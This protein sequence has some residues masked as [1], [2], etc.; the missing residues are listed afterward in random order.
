MPTNGGARLSD[1][2]AQRLF[3][4]APAGSWHEDF[5]ER[6]RLERERGDDAASRGALAGY[7]VARLVERSLDGVE[8][9]EER[10]AYAWQLDS[11]RR[12]VAELDKRRPET[13]HLEGIVESIRSSQGASSKGVRLALNAFAYF[14]ENEGRLAEA[15]DMLGLAARTHRAAMPAGEF[16]AVALFA[17]RLNRLQARF[18]AATA[19]YAAAEEGALVAL[20]ANSR[21]ISWLGRAHVARAQGNLPVART[22][23]EG[24]IAEARAQGLTD[25]LSRAYADLGHVLAAMGD[26]L[27][28]LKATYEAFRLTHDPITRMRNL[29]DLGVEL[30][31]LGF[32]D[33]ARTAFELV[34]TSNASFI[35]KTNAQLEL[36]DLESTAGNRVAF[37]RHRTELRDAAPRM[38]PSME[39]DFRYKTG[40]GLA[41]FGQLGRAREAWADGMRLAEAHRLNEWY[42]RLERMA[43]NLDGCDAPLRQPEPA[44]SPTAIADLTAGLRAYAEAAPA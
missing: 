37:E 2:T 39:I 38:P 1:F 31:E 33:T 30:S 3:G 8:S 29:G 21:L 44:M 22:T 28:A 25:V 19:A 13:R 7:L 24:V 26:R 23:V 43:A 17:G 10:Q 42:F 14:L 27:E 15:L 6:A 5:L 18:D 35:V 32:Y 41:R 36:M 20:D 16:T 11:A 12:Y 9:D 40:I 34:V 4:E